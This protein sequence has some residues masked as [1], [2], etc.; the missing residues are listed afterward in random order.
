MLKCDEEI[1]KIPNGN[2]L[3][4]LHCDVMLHPKRRNKM[5]NAKYHTMRT[6]PKSK[7]NIIEKVKLDSPYTQLHVRSRSCLGKKTLISSSGATVQ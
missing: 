7:R 2:R 5:S 4:L 1:L 3:L 6:V